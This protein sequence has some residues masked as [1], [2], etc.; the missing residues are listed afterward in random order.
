[1]T[2]LMELGYWGLLLAAFL[3]ATII[4]FSSDV[5]LGTMLFGDFDPLKLW[6]FAIIGNWLGGMVS[7]YMGRLGKWAWIEKYFGVKHAK[8]VKWRTY[9]QNYGYWFALITWLPVIGDPIAIALGFGRTSLVPTMLLMF[10]G[11]GARYALIIWLVLSGQEWIL[12]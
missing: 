2:T 1:M 10:I 12:I 8:V 11:K 3:A 9:T 7:Y 4:P 5:L 6:I